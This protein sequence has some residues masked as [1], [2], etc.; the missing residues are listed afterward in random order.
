MKMKIIKIFIVLFIMCLCSCTSKENSHFTASTIVKTVG[1]IDVIVDPNVEMMIILQRLAVQPPHIS[2][3]EA[4]YVASYLAKVDEYFDPYKSSSAIGML[5]TLMLNNQRPSE[6]GMYLN[7][8]DSAF[9]MKPNNEIFVTSDGPAKEIY[10]YN[11]PKLRKAVREFRIESNFDQFFLSNTTEYQELIDKH[12]ELLNT[13]NFDSWLESFYGIK[14]SENPCLYV[15]RLIGNFGIQFVNPE[16]KIIPHA[17]IFDQPGPA[18]M[19]FIISHEFSHPMTHDICDELYKDTTV[20]AIFDDLFSDNAFIYKSFGIGNGLNILHETINQACANKFNE[21]IFTE[22]QM[23][24]LYSH[25]ES[26]KYIYVPVI[27]EFLNNY[28]DNRDEYKT[29]E[30]FVPE[31]RKFLVTLE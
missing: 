16:G 11:Y 14:P 20:R 12:V 28:Q 4:P 19:L 8:D 24:W 15:N 2:V 21:E 22:E 5:K 18:G 27:S 6:F 13:A 26:R 9:I 10:H 17:V 23:Q 3:N 1:N 30:D 7:S 31:L 25:L 29:L